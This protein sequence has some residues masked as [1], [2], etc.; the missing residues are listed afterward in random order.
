ME[1]PTLLDPASPGIV[2]LL[3]NPGYTPGGIAS[4]PLLQAPGVRLVWM[5]MDAGQELTEHTTPKRALVE[6]LEG[7]CD[8]LL[9]GEWR[10]LGPGDLVHLTPGLIHAVK[11]ITRTAFLL[12]LIPA[13]AAG[14]AQSAASPRLALTAADE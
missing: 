3:L 8:F 5:G 9:G 12:I 14:A 7:T 1:K 10:Q 4:R 2:P 11:A 6:I 13:D